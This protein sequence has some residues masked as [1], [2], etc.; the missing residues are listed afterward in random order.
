MLMSYYRRHRPFDGESTVGLEHQVDFKLH[1]ARDH[2]FVGIIDLLTCL[3]KGV[4]EVH[5][6][7]TGR[8]LPTAQDLKRDR[9][10]AM[11]EIGVRRTFPDVK[12]VRLVWHYLAHDK[13]LR[14]SRTLAELDELERTTVGLIEVIEGADDHP[15]RTGPLCRWCEY[16]GICERA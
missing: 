11:Y 1:G 6:Y 12:E 10:L 3:G 13:E 15:R 8:R 4:Y 16:D 9:Q 5:D 14:S 7:K 2:D